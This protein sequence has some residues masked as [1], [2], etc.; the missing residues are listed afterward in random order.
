MTT[1]IIIVADLQRFKLYGIKKDPIGRESVELVQSIDNLETHESI[2]DK[3]SDQ[4]GNFQAFRASGAVVASGAGEN[5][6]L[7]IEE[8][9]RRIKEIASQIS[10]HLGE[11]SY[12]SWYFAAPKSI[13][14][15]I[16]ELIDPVVKSTM[17]INLHLD[18]TKTPNDQLL[19]HFTK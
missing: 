5:H 14:N 18:L 10:T 1:K 12:D 4:K 6:N 19:E 9:H 11:C 15:Q 7:E 3:V 16:I 17:E 2:S 13:N 8:V